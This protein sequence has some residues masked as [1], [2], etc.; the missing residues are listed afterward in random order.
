MLEK[1]VS[2]WLPAQ[3][4]SFLFP[5]TTLL[6]GM[7]DLDMMSKELLPTRYN[8]KFHMGIWWLVYVTELVIKSVSQIMKCIFLYSEIIID[9]NPM[10]CPIKVNSNTIEL[11][12][13]TY[14]YC[15]LDLFWVAHDVAVL[16]TKHTFTAHI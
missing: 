13:H 16:W 10:L 1:Y 6:C 15:V 11:T 4:F 3:Q 14:F 5:S 9:I 12:G 7:R 8:P 2:S